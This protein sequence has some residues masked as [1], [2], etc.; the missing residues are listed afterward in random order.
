MEKMEP[1]LLTFLKIK[2]FMHAK[3]KDFFS[4]HTLTSKA[5]Q[6]LTNWLTS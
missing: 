2:Q 3:M 6:T 4:Q 1:K 5:L